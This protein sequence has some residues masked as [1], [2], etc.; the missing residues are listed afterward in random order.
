MKEYVVVVD[1]VDKAMAFET[2]ARILQFPEISQVPEAVSV[3]G[4]KVVVRVVDNEYAKQLQKV[5]QQRLEVPESVSI[6]E[7]IMYVE[8]QKDK[9]LPKGVKYV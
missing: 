3:R 5:L 8:K 7:K 9:K 1:C 4:N 2:A 6:E